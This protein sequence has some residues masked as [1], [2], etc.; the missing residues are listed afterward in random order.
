[1]C[2]G[3][4]KYSIDIEVLWYLIDVLTKTIVAFLG[5]EYACS[6]TFVVLD[7][8]SIMIHIKKEL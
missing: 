6:R 8:C 1:M 2:R 5:I 3:N 7:D 4:R